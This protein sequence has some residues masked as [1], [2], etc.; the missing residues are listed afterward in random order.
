MHT[1]FEAGYQYVGSA[2]LELTILLSQVQG[3]MVPHLSKAPSEYFTIG[4]QD[5]QTKAYGLNSA[6]TCFCK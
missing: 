3:Y 2:G 5:Q 1:C 4:F 6:A